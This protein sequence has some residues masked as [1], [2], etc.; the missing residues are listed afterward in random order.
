MRFNKEQLDILSEYED[1]FTTA[2]RMDYY[3]NLGSKALNAINDVWE[4][5]EGKKLPGN[6]SCGHCILTFLKT[7]GA[8]YF[9]DKEEYE[10]DA[11]ELLEILDEDVFQVPKEPE[12]T[13]S[14]RS[15]FGKNK[16][17]ATNKK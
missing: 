9:K 14:K 13:P 17:K 15:W 1:R 10:K 3:R 11:V 7:V 6:W 5:A 4:Q 12:H 16:N 2:V 8:K